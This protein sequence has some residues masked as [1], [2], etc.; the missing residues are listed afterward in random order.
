MVT[1]C[2]A[3]EAAIVTEDRLPQPTRMCLFEAC[4]PLGLPAMTLKE[5]F[6]EEIRALVRASGEVR[7]D[8]RLSGCT[9]VV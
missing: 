5:F 1:L 4:E 8:E 7:A 2:E 3:S 9:A 6:A